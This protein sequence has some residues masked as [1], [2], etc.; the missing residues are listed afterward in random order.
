M[1]SKFVLTEEE[2][3][4]ILSLH[5]E[6]IKEERQEVQESDPTW[7]LGYTGLGAATGAGLGALAFGPIG[8]VVGGI[9][10]GIYGYLSTASG[11]ITM[12]LQRKHLKCVG[13]KRKPLPNQ[14]NHNK[15]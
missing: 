10:G 3:K 1:K 12:R 8:A 2:S 4:R 13:L 14:K 7:N 15:D 11:N 9:G 6:R 5:K